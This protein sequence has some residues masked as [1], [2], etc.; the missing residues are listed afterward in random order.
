VGRGGLAD[1]L[2]TEGHEAWG[3]PHMTPHDAAWRF[4]SSG[5]I[6]GAPHF[7]VWLVRLVGLASATPGFTILGVK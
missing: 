5:V 6:G 4:L 7:N 2:R 3:L 1:L